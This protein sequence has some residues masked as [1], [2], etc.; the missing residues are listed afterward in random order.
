MALEVKELVIKLTVKKTDADL[1]LKSAADIPSYLKKEIV[2][3]CVEKVL[4]RL[5]S[6][7]ER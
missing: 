2:K 5:E 1:K 3:D 7:I 4:Q 6:K